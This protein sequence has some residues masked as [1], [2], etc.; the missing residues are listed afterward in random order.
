MILRLVSAPGPAQIAANEILG[1]TV[2]HIVP[3]AKVL[4]CAVCHNPYEGTII[5]RFSMGSLD[6]NAF[7]DGSSS[8]HA[9]GKTIYLMRKQI[10]YSKTYLVLLAAI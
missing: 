9:I 10:R 4:C 1:T 3:R 6:A 8:L 7:V 5:V 2:Y